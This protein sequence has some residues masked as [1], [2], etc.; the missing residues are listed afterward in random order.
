M[1][2]FFKKRE[3]RKS[4]SGGSEER[5]VPLK[6]GAPGA[7]KEDFSLFLSHRYIERSDAENMAAEHTSHF[8]ERRRYNVG[9]GT[10]LELSRMKKYENAGAKK[11]KERNRAQSETDQ[12]SCAFVMPRANS[13]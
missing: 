9:N 10:R 3:P 6:G 5:G 8:R 12:S 1:S 11:N 7:R 13:V 4:R 2:L